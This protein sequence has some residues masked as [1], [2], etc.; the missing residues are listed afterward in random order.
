MGRRLGRGKLQDSPTNLKREGR[1]RQQRKLA[2][3][4]KR[5]KSRCMTPR[6]GTAAVG[7]LLQE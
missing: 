4:A 1:T 5:Q 6:W 2:K 7:P 3:L